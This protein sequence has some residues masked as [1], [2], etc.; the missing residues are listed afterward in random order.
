M[1]SGL[2]LSFIHPLWPRPPWSLPRSHD[3][4]ILH[5]RLVFLLLPDWSGV[6]LLVH[7]MNPT[8]ALPI[9]PVLGYFGLLLP[10]SVWFP[11]GCDYTSPVIS[12]CSQFQS[13]SQLSQEQAEWKENLPEDLFLLL[14]DSDSSLLVGGCWRVPRA[15]CCWCSVTWLASRLLCS[16]LSGEGEELAE[17]GG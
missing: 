4:C 15:L 7:S 11:L 8:F 2:L 1:T 14:C 3:R 6:L 17:A 13:C 5:L 16:S 12:S 10:I 9:V